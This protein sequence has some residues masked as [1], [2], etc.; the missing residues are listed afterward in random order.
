MIVSG[1]KPP[2]AATWAVFQSDT[3]VLAKSVIVGAL[4]LT[5]GR[6]RFVRMSR[7]IEFSLIALLHSC[8][9][10]MFAASIMCLIAGFVNVV[11]IMSTLGNTVSHVSGAATKFGTRSGVIL[12]GT[13]VACRCD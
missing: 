10:C 7:E 9:R 6:S 4:T 5:R 8:E 12:H 13:I 2:T 1:G 3:F 11:C